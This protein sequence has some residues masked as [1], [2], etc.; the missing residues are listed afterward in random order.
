M[1]LNSLKK[2]SEEVLNK[3]LTPCRNWGELTG[4]IC[5]EFNAERMLKVIDAV[6]NMTESEKERLRSFPAW[7]DDV[8]PLKDIKEKRNLSWNEVR[9]LINKI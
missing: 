2:H 5:E 3:P 8:R 4:R 6:D 1:T 7:Q 9:M